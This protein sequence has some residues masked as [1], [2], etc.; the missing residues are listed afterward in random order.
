MIAVG[1]LASPE[2]NHSLSYAPL[3]V[4]AEAYRIAD[5]RL[6]ALINEICLFACIDP[7][8]DNTA[9]TKPLL[10]QRPMPP[11]CQR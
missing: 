2:P 11:P 7:K 10:P 1:E 3:A 5:A 4:I 6:Q 9:T 8:G